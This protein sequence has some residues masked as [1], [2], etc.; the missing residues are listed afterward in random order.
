MPKKDTPVFD[1]GLG[2]ITPSEGPW[3]LADAP[4]DAEFLDFGP[5]RL[6]KIPGLRARVEMDM[7][8]DRIGAVAVYV[9]DGWVQLQVIGARSG[10]G[11]WTGVRRAIADRL[12]R[13]PGHQH[14]VEGRF[15]T[16]LIATVTTRDEDGLL[17]DAVMRFVGIDG[18]RWLLRAVATGGSV[19]TDA[20]VARVD[21]LLSRIAIDRG[22][23]ALT[24]GEVM[25][26][27][28]PPGHLDDSAWAEQ[29]A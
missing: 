19:T 21:A 2:D 28:A 12:K 20:A 6:P 24:V 11:A 29:G 13:G 10:N 22:E 25:E 15:G 9:A 3:S 16:E 8:T 27:K 4:A 26:L 7:R 18:D 1:D 17:H 14:I 23:E 5:L